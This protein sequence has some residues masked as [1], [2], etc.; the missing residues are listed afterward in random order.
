MARDRSSAAYRLGVKAWHARRA[1][2]YADLVARELGYDETGAFLVWGDPS[3]YDST[4]RV[5]ASGPVDFTDQAMI[6]TGWRLEQDG[7]AN[8]DDVLVTPD[9]ITSGG[10]WSTDPADTCG[11][12]CG[13]GLDRGQLLAPVSKTESRQRT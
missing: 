3:L 11:G 13:Q 1:S 8:V 9:E 6:A 5:L 7:Q 4:L 12:A 2:I 10:R